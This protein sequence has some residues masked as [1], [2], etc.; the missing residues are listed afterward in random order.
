MFKKWQILSKT[1]GKNGYSYGFQKLFLKQ[2][3]SLQET[4]QYFYI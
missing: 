4:L 2:N 3:A 1:H